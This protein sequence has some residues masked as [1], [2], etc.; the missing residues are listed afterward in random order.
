MLRLQ[1]VPLILV[2]PKIWQE[3]VMGKN[4]AKANP[5][6][7]ALKLATSLWPKQDWHVGR[8]ANP[9]DG[10]IDASLLAFYGELLDIRKELDAPLDYT[11]P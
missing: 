6:D 9:H 8:Q 7:R 3:T 4:V 5:K 2:R 11:K 1:T 10:Q